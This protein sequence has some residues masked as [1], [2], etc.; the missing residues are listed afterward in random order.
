VH[1]HLGDNVV[2]TYAATLAILEAMHVQFA[3]NVILNFADLLGQ[4]ELI[5]KILAEQRI[6]RVEFEQRI[7][8]VN[9]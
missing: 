7:Q 2:L 9:S 6:G 5:R 8:K 4:P 1:A 3:D